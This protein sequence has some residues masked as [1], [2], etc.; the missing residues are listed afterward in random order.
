VEGRRNGDFDVAA[1][2]RHSVEMMRVRVFIDPS[3]AM[4]QVSSFD[5]NRVA[6]GLRSM[7]RRDL[8]EVRADQCSLA[9]YSLDQPRRRIRPMGLDKPPQELVGG[10]ILTVESCCVACGLL[11][12]RVG[13]WPEF[14]SA[15]KGRQ[16]G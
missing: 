15:L 13:A 10:S 2:L 4:R 1:I 14:G 11:E 7:I 9:N 6:S 8:R 12:G 3:D 5:P 16:A